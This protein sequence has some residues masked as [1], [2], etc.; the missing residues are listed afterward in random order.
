M[1]QVEWE[2]RIR[3]NKR[4][5]SSGSF[6]CSGEGYSKC[7]IKKSWFRLWDWEGFTADVMALS[8]LSYP[9]VLLLLCEE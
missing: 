4:G 1:F 5:D 8:M 6:L 2:I 3:Q 9:L 7:I